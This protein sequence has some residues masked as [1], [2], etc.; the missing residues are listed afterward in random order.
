MPVFWPSQFLFKHLLVVARIEKQMRST[1]R[2]SQS[3]VFLFGRLD[4]GKG[5]GQGF[6]D[7]PRAISAA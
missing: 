2:K 4:F 1:W 7:L 6:G 5:R 3:I